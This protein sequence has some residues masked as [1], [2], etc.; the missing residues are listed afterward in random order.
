MD[1]RKNSEQQ[2]VLMVAL[3]DTSP[4]PGAVV[5]VYFDAGLAYAAVK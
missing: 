3:A 4:D 2:E 1:R 5:I